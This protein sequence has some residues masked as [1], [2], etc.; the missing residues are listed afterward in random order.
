MMMTILGM[1]LG[2]C[3]SG[4]IYYLTGNYQLAFVNCIL[5]NGLNIAIILMLLRRSRPGRERVMA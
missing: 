5:C 4:W 3:M 2:G 1:A